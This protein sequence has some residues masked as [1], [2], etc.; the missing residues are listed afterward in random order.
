MANRKLYRKIAKENGVSHKEVKREMQLAIE[1]AYKNNQ[2]NAEIKA[3]QNKVP[4]KGEIPTTD[5]F[6]NFMV[7]EIKSK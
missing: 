6:I 1:Y 4:H 2:D 7:K 5:E 3:Y